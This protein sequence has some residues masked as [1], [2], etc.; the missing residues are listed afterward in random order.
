MSNYD[1]KETDLTLADMQAAWFAKTVEESHHGAPDSFPTLDSAIAEYVGLT[2]DTADAAHA[3]YNR[4]ATVLK[5]YVVFMSERTTIPFINNR[6]TESRTENAVTWFLHD[7][8]WLATSPA[9]RFI[10]FYNRKNVNE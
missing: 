1:A 2:F 3:E 7:A 9:Y 8:G 10:Y 4:G 6:P 5:Q